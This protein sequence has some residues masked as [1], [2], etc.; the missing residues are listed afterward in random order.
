M[1][2]VQDITITRHTKHLKTYTHHKKKKK[3]H[4]WQKKEEKTVI[5]VHDDMIKNPNHLFFF[6][7]DSVA[8]MRM[9]GMRPVTAF[10]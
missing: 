10:L 1:S 5:I 7:Q 2:N 9:P 4:R 8:G 3:A 6:N